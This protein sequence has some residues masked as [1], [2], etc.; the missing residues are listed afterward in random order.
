MRHEQ[1]RS[2]EPRQG[3]DQ[4]LLGSDAKR[5]V[6]S[7]STRKCGGSN[8]I[9]AIARR[10]FSPLDSTPAALL[11]VVA[12]ETEAAGERAQRALS[13]LRERGFQVGEDRRLAVEQEEK[14]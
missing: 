3:R 11:H 7:S 8:S 9:L 13:G 5:F 10:A 6:S 2:L 14:P 12:G 4:H 1:H